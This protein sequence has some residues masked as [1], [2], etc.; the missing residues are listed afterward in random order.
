MYLEWLVFRQIDEDPANTDF[1][2]KMAANRDTFIV[3]S[4]TQR[5]CWVSGDPGL[6]D[7]PK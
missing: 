2:E 7:G 4:R 1:E 6:W 5:V 3:I